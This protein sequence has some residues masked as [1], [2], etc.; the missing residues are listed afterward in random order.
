M[1]NLLVNAAIAGAIFFVVPLGLRIQLMLGCVAGG[2]RLQAPLFRL[3][4]FGMLAA[5]ISFIPGW[6]THLAWGWFAVS[7]LIA[8]NGF[9]L[10]CSHVPRSQVSIS[11]GASNIFLLVG[12]LFFAL[13]RNNISVLEFESE[14]VLLTAAHFHFAGY[15][16]MLLTGLIAN[17][18]EFSAISRARSRFVVTSVVI[19]IP[20][21]AIGITW[22]PVIEIIGAAALVIGACGL[23][24][25]QLKLSSHDSYASIRGG[26]I[27]SAVSLIIAMMLA[28]IY[29]IGEVCN[30]PWLSIPVMA[31]THG[32]LNSVGFA[33]VGLASWNQW[34]H[35]AELMAQ[36]TEGLERSGQ[37]TPSDEPQCYGIEGATE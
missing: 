23:A 11:I 32:I 5:A 14:I 29:A 36:S 3:L 31:F 19:G 24:A 20:L 1:Q 16:L 34:F 8:V 37:I 26:L 25:M 9:V 12:A 21:V 30:Q 15:A 2:K 17:R 7:L 22:S 35:E 4:P 6:T 27:T 28:A 13:S 10:I 33:L 18:A